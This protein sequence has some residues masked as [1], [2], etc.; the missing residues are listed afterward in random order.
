MFIS[1]SETERSRVSNEIESNSK[2]E[3][4]EISHE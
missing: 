3:F 4:Q 2:G 1:C